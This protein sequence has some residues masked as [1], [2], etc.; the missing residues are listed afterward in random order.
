MQPGNFTMPAAAHDPAGTPF[1]AASIH[2][3]RERSWMLAPANTGCAYDEVLPPCGLLY[4]S[5]FSQDDVLVFQHD[6][7]V[8][9]LTGFN[10]PDGVCSDKSGNVW[11][12]NNRG[13]SVVEYAHGGTK[14]IATLKDPGVY[15]LGCSVNPITGSVA[16][17]NFSTT[18][19]GRGSIAIYHHATGKPL[20]LTDPDIY[21]MYFCGY[22]SA[23]NLY[24]DGL[25]T[26]GAFQF[27]ELPRNKYK[28]TSITLD[29]TVYFPGNVQW[30]GKH[31]DVG[32]QMYQNSVASAVYRTDG[33]GGQVV[34]TTVLSDSQDVVGY[35]IQATNLIGP[36]ANLNDVGLY[37]Y[38]IGGKATLRVGRLHEPYG[39]AVSY[40]R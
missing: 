17:A 29:T 30:D 15:P 35:W 13:A 38:P 16:V 24:V 4:L 1:R 18:A 28:F 23:G 6:T 32:D 22:D 7:V 9:T 5:E 14:P 25:N 10:G 27:A 8:G 26:S 31:V 19:S 34:G 36:D 37:R 39:A 20:I 33:A 21:Y 2:P 12:S 3:N 40:P 11:I